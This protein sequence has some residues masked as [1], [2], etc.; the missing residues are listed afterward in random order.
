MRHAPQ[1]LREAGQPQHSDM[2]RNRPNPKRRRAAQRSASASTQPAHSQGSEQHQ[3]AQPAPKRTKSEG[4]YLPTLGSAPVVIQ[5]PAQA[6]HHVQAAPQQEQAPS[7]HAAADQRAAQLQP[8]LVGTCSEHATQHNDTS[9]ALLE[10]ESPHLAGEPQLT[11]EWLE[12][13]PAPAQ[14]KV[15]H[16]T[17]ADFQHDVLPPNHPEVV[18]RCKAVDEALFWLDLIR[19][20]KVTPELLARA[21][22]HVEAIKALL[23]DPD[24]FTA[25]G[26]T[27]YYHVWKHLLG[28]Y[29]QTRRNVKWLLQSIRTGVRWSTAV[30]QAQVRMPDHKAKLA[31]VRRMITKQ[32][33]SRAA[34]EMLASSVPQR[35][36]CPNHKSA[37]DYPAFV[38]EAVAA[39]VAT[40]AARELPPGEV[41]QCVHPIGVAD[42]KAPK[43][44]LILDPAYLNVLLKYEP[45][46]Y[47]QLSD[48]SYQARPG[49]WATTT[50]EKSGYH[51]MPLHPSM[52]TLFGFQHEGRYYVYTHMAFGIGPACRAYTTLKQELFR[53]VR[54]RGAV[55]MAFLIDD[56]CNLAPTKELAQLQAAAILAI[57]RALGFTLS[58]PKCQLTPT[59]HPHFLGMLVDL[60]ARCFRLPGA[61]IAEFQ[62]LVAELCARRTVTARDLAKPAGKLVSFAPAVGLS[63]L[64]SRQLYLAVKGQP[65]WDEHFP[66]PA[67][68]VDAMHWVASQLPSWN[69]RQWSCTRDVLRAA[70]DYSSLRGYAAYL[71]DRKLLPEPVIHTLT[72]EELAAVAAGELS[73][74]YGEL[75]VLQL[76]LEVLVQSH[77]HLAQGKLLVYETDNQAAMAVLNSMGGNAT[78][79]PLV[80]QI[81]ET[82]KA[83]DIELLVQWHPRD[84]A[85]QAEADRL[86]KLTDN[87][88][89]ALDQQVFDHWIAGNHWV[90]STKPGCVTID[91]CAGPGNAKAARFMSRFWCTGTE[92]VDMF[93]RTTWAWHPKTGDR[94][95]CYINGD[96]SQMGRIV[97]KVAKDKADCVIVYPDWPRYWRI[98]LQAL[99]IVDDF[100]LPR[101]ESL[102]RA[103]ARVDANKRRGAAS[104]PIRVA[105]VLWKGRTR[106]A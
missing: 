60:A 29:E 23:P 66:N 55:R 58:V 77:M 20:A 65:H 15:K 62:R 45:L 35:L 44:R 59:Q 17:Q 69:G 12:H 93:T 105:V 54:D 13:V 50:D 85:N 64:Y 25:G 27:R 72:K 31:R 104:Y 100:E 43:L 106:T 92:G 102:C 4:R 19:E 52:W 28:P 68:A 99:P 6:G 90:E 98:G 24:Q 103:S 67:A 2:R 21:G 91:L 46:R 71:L 41:P 70:G 73:S 63:V 39:A 88:E 97:A 87:S 18:A 5:P 74:T 86:S 7:E 38:Q 22:E 16:F 33:G 34:D 76:L 75:K 40:G 80:R 96:F 82:A 26:L 1:P 81:W 56:Q 79:Y 89:W 57:Q 42:N 49:D 11:E 95:L 30:P 32:L 53:V 3:L 83:A 8:P 61:K 36:E 47:E 84:T 14:A 37:A 10:A 78:N 9:T 94:E 48:L 101:F 51:H